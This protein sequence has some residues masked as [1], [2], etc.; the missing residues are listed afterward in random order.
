[1]V[2]KIVVMDDEPTIADLY[3]EALAD[4]GY[5]TYRVTQSL[6]FFDAIKVKEEDL[7]R[8]YVFD[9]QMLNNVDQISNDVDSL[10]SAV[11]QGANIGEAIRQL[12]NDLGTASEIFNS[13]SEVLMGIS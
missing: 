13:R 3:T 6:R 2:K 8:I 7:A 12:N 11:S 9:E 4:V 5:E 1:M 10:D